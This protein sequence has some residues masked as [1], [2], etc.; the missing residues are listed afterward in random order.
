[1]KESL[2]ISPPEKH[3]VSLTAFHATALAGR[4]KYFMP[5]SREITADNQIL[6]MV[7]RV[8]L[9]NSEVLILFLTHF[10]LTL[11]KEKL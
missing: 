5:A 6:E 3:Q 4:T 9:L 2:S 7:H 11:L 1:M 8:V 10:H